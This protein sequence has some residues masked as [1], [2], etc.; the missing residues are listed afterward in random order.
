MCIFPCQSCRRTSCLTS[1]CS[2][3]VDDVT[4][5]QTLPQEFYA[6][7]FSALHKW[8]KIIVII[9]ITIS[10]DSLLA[11]AK[12]CEFKSLAGAAGEFISPESTLC[13]DSHLVSVSTPV[14]PQLHVKDPGH[15]ATS[16]GGRL[17]LNTHTPLTQ[18]SRSGL[19]MPLSKHSVGTYQETSSRATRQGSLGHNHLSSLSHC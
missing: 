1:M 5:D 12:C 8:A 2:F 7:N 15:S 3:A 19:T 14:L 4:G 13:A 10:Q 18:Q 17:H 9:I 16:V 11:R 6:W